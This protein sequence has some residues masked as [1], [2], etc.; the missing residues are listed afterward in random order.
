MN[1][2]RHADAHAYFG[3]LI[4]G[5]EDLKKHREFY[6]EYLSSRSA[7]RFYLETICEVFK[8]HSLAE[9]K[10]MSYTV[11]P[12]S[13]ADVALLT[14]KVKKTIS[15]AKAKQKPPKICAKTFPTI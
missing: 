12:E 1:L 15:L 2:E 5:D 8:Y 14:I 7:S 4:R 10:L 3:H 9:N 6:D 13:I 11:R